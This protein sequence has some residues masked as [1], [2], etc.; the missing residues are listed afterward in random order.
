MASQ[1]KPLHNSPYPAA[2][3]L[4]DVRDNIDRIDVELVALIAQRVHFIREATKFKRGAHEA[5]VPERVEDVA[6]KV[7]A[8][9]EQ[10]GFCP[11]RAETIWRDMMEQCIAFEEDYMTIYGGGLE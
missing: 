9:A 2:Q 4:Q 3:S 5:L 10:V 11:D 6:Q 8:S 7:R 1:P